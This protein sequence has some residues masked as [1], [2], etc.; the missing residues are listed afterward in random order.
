MCI[1][2][3]V[4]QGKFQSAI[5]DFLCKSLV[6][7]ELQDALTELIYQSSNQMKMHAK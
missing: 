2:Y 5:D 7:H 4:A 6:F 3:P 1:K